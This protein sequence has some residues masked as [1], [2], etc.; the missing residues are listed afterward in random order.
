MY[1]KLHLLKMQ[2]SKRKMIFCI[3]TLLYNKLNKL[4][5]PMKII[6]LQIEKNLF[7]LSSLHWFNLTIKFLLL[8]WNNFWLFEILQVSSVVQPLK[9]YFFTIII[10]TVGKKTYIWAL[11]NLPLGLQSSD[12]RLPISD[13]RLWL[14]T[15][16]FWLPT[17]DFRLP[18]S[19]VAISNSHQG[20]RKLDIAIEASS[21][22]W[23]WRLPPFRRLQPIRSS[24]L[25]WSSPPIQSSPPIYKILHLPVPVLG[26][27]HKNKYPWEPS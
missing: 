7:I 11:G 19:E 2:R 16:D 20:S 25:I 5:V 14:P 3:F 27:T 15:S 17:S 1:V 23:I 13:F 22:F 9:Y 6:F 18:T 24:P 21:E 8:T 10:Y 26:K 4:N 12:F